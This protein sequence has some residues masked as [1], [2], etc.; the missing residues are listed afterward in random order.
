MEIV[1]IVFGVLFLAVVGILI[2]FILKTKKTEFVYEKMLEEIKANVENIK[3]EVLDSS[4][5]NLEFVQKEASRSLQAIT[6]VT[7]KLERLEATN[8]QIIN[9]TEQLQNLQQ[10]LTNPKHRGVLGEYYLETLLANVLPPKNYK[11][12]YKFSDGEIVDAVIFIGDKIIPIDSKFS[13][14]NYNRLLQEEDETKRKQLE[15][16][17]KRDLKQRIDEC[18]KYIR[19]SENTFDFVFM[20]IPAEGIYYDLMVSQIGAIRVSTRDL[21]EYAFSKRVLIVSPNSFYAYLQ[22]VLQ[23]LRAMAIEESAQEIRKNIEKL[24]VHILNFDNYMKKIGNSLKSTVTSY[25]QAYKEF[26]KIDKD[27][28]KITGSSTSIEPDL[29]EKPDLNE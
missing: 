4:S 22:T 17:F 12:Q 14:E 8:R 13:L 9:F 15:A 5:K 16:S 18:S 6:D 20:F 21:L 11:M 2:V 28:A 25:N 7:S 10:V 29:L 27:I 23:G 19:P 1:L 24:S 3:K 26:G